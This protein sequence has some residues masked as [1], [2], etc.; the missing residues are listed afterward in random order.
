MQPGDMLIYRTA[1]GGGWKDR[2]D[3]PVEAVER[4]VAFGLVS[5][6]EGAERVR[7]G[8]RRRRRPPTAE[9]DRQRAERGD[10]AGVRLRPAA[11]R[12]R[13]RAARPETGLPA[14]GAG[15]A[16]A[17][18]AAG[19]PAS[20][21]CGAVADDGATWPHAASAAAAGLRAERGR[22]SSSSTSTSR[23][24]RPGVAA[25][26][27]PRRRAHTHGYVARRGARGRACRCSSP[28]SSTTRWARPR[29]P[30]S[31]ARSPALKRAAA[32]ARRGSRSTRGSAGCAAEPV[33][34][35]AHASAFFGMPFA[36]LLAGRDTLI[37]CGASTS[38]LRPRDGRRRDAAR[39]RPD[40]ATR[41]R[42][43]PLISCSRAGAR[44]TSTAAT[45][46]CVAPRR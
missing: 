27:R 23:L 20:P 35:K 14:A 40:R 2:L 43:R 22:R 39:V 45:A 42:R 5:R 7:R 9:R 29:P 18:V 25:R 6:G 19:V 36:A 34:V 44:R 31:C 11:R 21:R 15:E 46:T 33:L 41:V 26:V 32:R 10:A 24:H 37:V 17:L 8:R 3:R 16:A 30:S 28:R 38:G 1:G 4:D 13:S 12:T